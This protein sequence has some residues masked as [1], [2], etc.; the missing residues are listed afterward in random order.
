MQGKDVGDRALACSRNTAFTEVCY[1]SS[2]AFRRDLGRVEG[3]LAAWVVLGSMLLLRYCCSGCLFCRQ[4]FD[5]E[6]YLHTTPLWEKTASAS[7]EDLTRLISRCLPH[8][9]RYPMDG[10]WGA[11]GE[12]NTSV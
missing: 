12:R 9:G 1:F 11:R 7:L 3:S 4:E 5:L 2:Q 6:G 8:G 10:S